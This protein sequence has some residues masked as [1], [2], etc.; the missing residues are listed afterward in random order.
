MVQPEG[1]A[2][3]PARLGKINRRLPYLRQGLDLVAVITFTLQLLDA[4]L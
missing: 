1:Y 3:V 2:V 4:L